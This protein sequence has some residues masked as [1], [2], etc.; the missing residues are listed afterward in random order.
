MSEKLGKI[1]TISTKSSSCKI[2]SFGAHVLSWKC[3]GEERLFLSKKAVMDGSKAIR[4][5]V[6]IFQIFHLSTHTYTPTPTQIPLVFPQFGQPSKSLPSHGFAR[7]S[8]WDVLEKKESDSKSTVVF[9]LTPRSIAAE[10]RDNFDYDYELKLSLTLSETN[11]SISLE[12]KNCG[13]KKFSCQ[14]LLHTYLKVDAIEK[15]KICGFA[16]GKYSDKLKAGKTFT[17]SDSKSQVISEE[18]DR[19]YKGP[20]NRKRIE[21]E[22]V[23]SIENDSDKPCDVV[24]WNPWIAKSKRMSDL[25]DNEYHNFLCVEPGIVDQPTVIVPGGCVRLSQTLTP[26]SKL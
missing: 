1:I 8:M 19:I 16:A 3:K 9:V 21:I 11:L 7:I 17:Q 20:Y 2:S 14:M 23:I 6:C 13:S 4:G 5:G 10:F 25:D 12:V 15:T 18:T 26:H 24:L 22:D